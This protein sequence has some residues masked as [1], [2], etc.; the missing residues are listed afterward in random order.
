MHFSGTGDSAPGR[1]PVGGMETR[2]RPA[3]LEAAVTHDN[4]RSS[5]SKDAQAVRLYTN[6]A[7]V[8]ELEGYP[9][10]AQTLRELAES[11]AFFTDGHLDFLR[12]TADPLTGVPMGSTTMNLRAALTVAEET[13]EDM[14]PAMIA[15]ARA[16]GFH[17][18]ASWFDCVEKAKRA[19][20]Q[21]LREALSAAQGT[22]E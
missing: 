6:F 2:E 14:L 18:V 12:R 17:D 15:T 19:H 10:A 21:R 1:R 20:R 11:L 7:R 22:E 13:G 3:E 8:A 4:L 16:E 5:F 9:D